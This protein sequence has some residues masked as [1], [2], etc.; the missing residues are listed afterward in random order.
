MNR[1]T[2]RLNTQYFVSNCSSKGHLRIFGFYTGVY[3]IDVFFSG[4]IIIVLTN[5]FFS[6]SWLTVLKDHTKPI[7]RRAPKGR[8]PRQ[9]V[10]LAEALCD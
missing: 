6:A 10:H 8:K 5:G 4:T 2:P 1:T 9:E 7:L 3:E